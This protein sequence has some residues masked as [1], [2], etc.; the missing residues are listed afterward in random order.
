MLAAESPPV[1]RCVHADSI[2]LHRMS[3]FADWPSNNRR[4]LRCDN[5]HSVRACGRPGPCPAPAFSPGC[6]WRA[7]ARLGLHGV[8]ER[9]FLIFP[10]F[11]GHVRRSLSSV[12]PKCERKSKRR[13]VAASVAVAK[14]GKV[15]SPPRTGQGSHATKGEQPLRAANPGSRPSSTRYPWR[16]AVACGL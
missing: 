5:G 11:I 16:P 2:N 1:R 10:C 7:A 12:S 3:T 4:D 15:K 14:R 9:W 6:F 8:Q 13:P